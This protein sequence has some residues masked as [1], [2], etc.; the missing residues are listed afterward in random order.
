MLSLVPGTAF[1]MRIIQV[2]TVDCKLSTA[3]PE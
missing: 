1:F 3:P 2:W